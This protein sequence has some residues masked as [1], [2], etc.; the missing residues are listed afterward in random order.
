MEQRGTSIHNQQRQQQ[1]I[2]DSFGNGFS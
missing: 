2:R 1:R